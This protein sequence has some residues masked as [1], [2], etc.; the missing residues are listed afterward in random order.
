MLLEGLHIPLTTPFHPDGRLNTLKLAANVVRYSRTPAAGLIVLGPSGEPTLL[1]DDETHIVLRTAAEA[2]APEKVL[3]AGIARDSVRSTL[4]LANFAAAHDY[5]SVLVEVPSMLAFPETDRPQSV[6]HLRQ[7]LTYFQVIADRSPL[8]VMLL[9]IPGRAIPIDAV[10]ELAAHSNIIGLLTALPRATNFNSFE[11]LTNLTVRRDATVTPTFGAV[12]G[13]MK[14]SVRGNTLVSAASLTNTTTALAEP[15]TPT[16]RTRTK[17]VGFQ[18]LTGETAGMLDALQAGAVGAAPAFA[19][20][21]PQACYEVFAAWKDD[22][23][24]LAAEKQSR[25]LEAAGL[26]EAAPGALKFACDLNGYFGGHPRLP[27]LPPNGTQRAELQQQM[28]SLRS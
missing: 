10:A 22:D 19:A 28:K 15:A 27:Y 3:L 24:P 2:A 8:P 12:T 17:S 11:R 20:A 13:R 21:A 9:S 26:A 14:K 23:Q 7:L 16:L 25:L 18:I 4:T 6:T 1:S 5:D